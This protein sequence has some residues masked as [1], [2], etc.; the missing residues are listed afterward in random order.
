MCLPPQDESS[1][2]YFLEMNNLSKHYKFLESSMGMS[3]DYLK[4]IEYNSTFLRIGTKI[5]GERNKNIKILDFLLI[6]FINI[7]K[8]F[9]VNIQPAVFL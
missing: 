7:K 8:S 5:F 2:K 3:S 4:A 1:E 9:L 6:I